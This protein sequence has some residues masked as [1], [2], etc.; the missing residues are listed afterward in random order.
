MSRNGK[1]PV[2]TAMLDLWRPPR[3]AGDPVGCLATTYTFAP[4][5]FDEQCLARFLEIESEPDRESLAFLLERESRL[6]AIYSGVLVD[7]THAGVAHSLRWDVLPV[8]VSAGIQH[9]KLTLLAWARHIRMV[10]ASANLT[11]AG[12]RCNWEVAVAVDLT[13]EHADTEVLAEALTFLRG[14]IRRVPGA[15]D[16]PPEVQRAD[17]FLERVEGLARSWKPAGRDSALR[18]RL[19]L[20]QPVEGE[21]TQ[22][23]SALVEAVEA[24]RTRGGSPDRVRVASP[25]FDD[26][27]GAKQ[28]TAS[29]CKLMARGGGRRISFCVPAV[30]DQSETASVRLAAPIALLR[31]P[32]AYDAEV[33]FEIVP[34]VEDKNRRPWHAKL[35]ALGADDYSALMIGSSNFTGAGMGLTPRRNTEANLLTV[36]DRV[37]YGR[38][39][40]QLDALW[41]SMDQVEH[42]EG[43]E[44]LGARPDE[45]EAPAPLV[46][47]GFLSAS[48]RA[49]A[50]RRVILRLDPPHL[51]EDWVVEACGHDP[52]RL[53]SASAWRKDGALPRLEIEWKPVPPPEKLV[54]RWADCE[55]FL[56]VN[57]EDARALPPPPQLEKMSAEDMLE[58]L[59]ASDP[60]AAFRVWAKRQ[61]DGDP[62]D[63]DLDSATPIDLDPLR[64]YDLQATFLH[65]V[66]RR[67]RI[68]AQLRANL[69]RPVWSRQA[70]EWRL[71]GIIGVEALANRLV[72]EIGSP[73]GSADEA[74]L[75]LA[76]FLIVLHEVEYEP[77]EGS[78][79]KGEFDGLFR[80]FLKQLAGTLD[81][82]IRGLQARLSGQAAGF[83]DRV[84][85]RCRS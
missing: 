20:T 60:S 51:P 28:A 82:E 52:Q 64:R 46:P 44:W 63:A 11:K 34:E 80:T 50:Q 43:A 19:V 36:A 10:V 45:D 7:H 14:L 23:R 9:A 79:S 38:E 71:R 6:D 12:Y 30:R 81:G 18:Q 76:D 37:A 29:L 39:V 59:A 48:Y 21:A 54:V 55:A 35:V 68:L 1:A 73:T 24:C 40:G 83:W 49:G 78:L 72:R 3:S 31:T 32:A 5:L 41:P 66:R 84:V 75:T 70:L 53:T 22:A 27:E 17:A 4:E 57:V 77:D 25:F 47:S 74:L 16:S 67:A 65:R 85:E 58:I 2:K 33:A 42:P 62:F 61:E 8:R 69:Q 26:E 13:P 56:P 15:S